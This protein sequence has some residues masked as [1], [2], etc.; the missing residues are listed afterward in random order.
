METGMVEKVNLDRVAAQI[1]HEV[2]RKENRTHSNAA[3][4]MIRRAWAAARQ[5][6]PTT[7]SPAPAPRADTAA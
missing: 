7:P 5:P 3:S 1:V 4:T 2:A 6:V